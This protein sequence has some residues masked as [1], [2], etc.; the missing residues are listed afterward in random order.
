MVDLEGLGNDDSN[1]GN[2]SRSLQ[3]LGSQLPSCFV[4]Q[5]AVAYVPSPVLHGSRCP[6][7]EFVTTD[8]CCA[9]TLGS[10]VGGGNAAYLAC[11]EFCGCS[12]DEFVAIRIPSKKLVDATQRVLA[13]CAKT[14]V[15]GHVLENYTC[16][17]SGRDLYDVDFGDSYGNQTVLVG[18]CE[19]LCDIE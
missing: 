19:S 10:W 11:K 17:S 8:D 15:V 1:G 6:S 4:Q 3:I 14:W 13:T 2:S 18:D 16:L 7:F 12:S 9:P 5:L